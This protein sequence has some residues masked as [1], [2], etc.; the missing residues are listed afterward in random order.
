MHSFTTLSGPYHWNT[1][2]SSVAVFLLG[3]IA[4]VVESGYSVGAALLLFG[5]LYSL[6]SRRHLTLTRDDY[7]IIGVLI[8]FGLVNILDAAIHQAGSRALDKPIRFILALFALVLV[9]KYP[10]RLTWLWAGLAL[11]G[12]LTGLW[13]GY[14]KFFLGVERAGGYTFVIQ[15]GNICML[16]GLLCLAA[17]GWSYGQRYRRAWMLVLLLGAAGGMLGS[18]LS[19]SRGGWVGLPLV[20]LVL[21]RSYSEFLSARLKVALPVFAIVVAIGLY[22][23]PQFGVQQRVQWVFHD[24]ALYQDGDSNTSLGAR[25]EMWKGAGQLFLEKPL[26]GWG[27]VHYKAAMTD[28]AEQGRAHEVVSLFGHPHNELLNNAAKRGLLGVLVLLALYLVPLRLF[29]RS[30]QAPD[31]TERSLAT[32]GVLLAVAYID[33]GLSQVFFAHNSGV[34]IYAFWLVVLWGCYRNRLDELKQAADD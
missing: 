12:V 8:A 13:A 22:S 29:G 27:D 7:L 1:L 15:F 4:L 31:L 32:A 24:L 5:G 26:L 25:F 18:L 14:Q 11:G 10:P 3:A 16:T 23:I 34:M 17:L 9:R 20:F 2:Y 6:F 33:F 19:G 21:Y 28:L 30:L